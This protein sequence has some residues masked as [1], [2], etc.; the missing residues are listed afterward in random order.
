MWLIKQRLINHNNRREK[1]KRL[2]YDYEVGHHTYII[3]YENYRKVERN[4]LGQFRTTKVLTNGSIR[5][6]QGINNEKINIRR[7]TPHF[8]DP[9]T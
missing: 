6:Q 9:S 7:L 1:A 3:R 5:I 2:Q 4:K 8:G